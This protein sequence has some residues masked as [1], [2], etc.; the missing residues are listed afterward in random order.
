MERMIYEQQ[1]KKVDLSTAVVDSHELVDQTKRAVDLSSRAST[2]TTKKENVMPFSGFLQPP[3][4]TY[5]GKKL[6]MDETIVKEDA[7]LASC[8]KRLGRWLV[9]V[10]RV[11]E[12]LDD[13][14]QPGQS[15]RDG[16]LTALSS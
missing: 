14:K 10:H 11:D 13:E 15:L 3:T 16:L 8:V 7:V 12:P 2:D 5:Y 6:E 1:M 9:D 4:E